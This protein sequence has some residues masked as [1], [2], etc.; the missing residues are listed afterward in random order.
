MNNSEF[1]REYSHLP[2]NIILNGNDKLQAL[3]KPDEPANFIIRKN[4]DVKFV[5]VNGFIIDIEKVNDWSGN[6]IVHGR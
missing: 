6:T 2:F 1:T 5:V 3:I 4:D